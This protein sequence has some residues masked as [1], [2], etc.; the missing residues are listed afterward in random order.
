MMGDGSGYL[1]LPGRPTNS[2][3]NRARAYCA[4]SRC[5]WGLFG[6][7][8]VFFLS[9]PVVRTLKWKKGL[10]FEFNAPAIRKDE[11]TIL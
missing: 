10:F 2:V 8:C 6:L 11:F 3:N 5:D 1:S 9:V 7:P 4:C